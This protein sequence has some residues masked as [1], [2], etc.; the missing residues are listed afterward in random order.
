MSRY[1]RKIK[2]GV[3]AG[4]SHKEFNFLVEYT[5]DFNAR[6]A[7]LVCGLQPETGYDYAKRPA[8]IEAI[9]FLLARRLEASDIDAEWVLMEAVDNVLIARE[10]GKIAASNGALN[11][12]AKHCNVDA[13]AAQKVKLDTADE[14]VDR[15]KRARQRTDPDEPSFL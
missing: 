5:K 4:L 8:M 1:N 2:H 10:Q 7:A 3:F 13:Y 15:L 9:E 12:V 11:I 6:R 14:V